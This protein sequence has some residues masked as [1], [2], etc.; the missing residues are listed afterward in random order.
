MLALA[1]SVKISFKAENIYSKSLWVSN[2]EKSIGYIVR[3]E[4]VVLRFQNWSESCAFHTLRK[5]SL[6]M[7]DWKRNRG[8]VS[9][10]QC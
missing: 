8:G 4:Q 1:W 2:V 7:K 3:E 10:G 5:V 6:D 9:E